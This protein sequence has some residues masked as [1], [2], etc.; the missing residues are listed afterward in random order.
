MEAGTPKKLTAFLDFATLPVS[1]VFPGRFIRESLKP[2]NLDPW[3][4]LDM[5]SP[6]VSSVG[7][8]S[9]LAFLFFNCHLICD[10][11]TSVVDVS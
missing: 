2:V 5:Q 3:R 1:L 9:I 4:G 6:S 11:E 7:Q 8:C 10:E